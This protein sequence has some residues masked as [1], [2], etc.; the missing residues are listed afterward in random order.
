MQEREGALDYELLKRT[1]QN[2]GDL[3]KLLANGITTN[4]YGTTLGYLKYKNFLYGSIHGY[5]YQDEY[6]ILFIV[7]DQVIT[8]HFFRKSPIPS[9]DTY[10][11]VI[12]AIQNSIQIK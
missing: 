10:L 12:R 2:V 9:G 8:I 11:Q 4:G 3:D 1:T 5:V 7:E 6:E